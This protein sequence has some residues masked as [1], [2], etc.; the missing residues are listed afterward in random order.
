[1]RQGLHTGKVGVDDVTLHAMMR[2][3]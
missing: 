1:M 3:Y 2:T